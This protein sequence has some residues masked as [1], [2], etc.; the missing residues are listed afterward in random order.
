M[1]TLQITVD[2]DTQKLR[3]KSFSRTKDI[4][5]HVFSTM[6]NPNYSST[7]F[8][9]AVIVFVTIMFS[10]FTSVFKS[11]EEYHDY[12]IWETAEA[13]FTMIF[14]MELLLRVWS[15]PNREAL[16]WDP[17]TFIDVAATIPFYLHV[18]FNQSFS[19]MEVL[20][21]LRLWKLSRHYSGSLVLFHALRES[22]RALG[23]PAFFL[24][25]I[26]MFF[27]TLLYAIEPET[28]VSIPWAIYF[29]IVTMSTVGYGDVTASTTLGW[30]V[31]LILICFGVLFMAMPLG[32]M[33]S[34]VVAAW[35]DK[36]KIILVS[37]LQNHFSK[38]G[39]GPS[40]VKD[41]FKEIDTDG[42]GEIDFDE[43]WNFLMG[44]Q[45]GLSK[46][47][48]RTLFLAIDTS[49]QGNISPA[50]FKDLIFANVDKDD[51]MDEIEFSP[52]GTSR[53]PSTPLEQTRSKIS[54]GISGERAGSFFGNLTDSDN[55]SVANLQLQM[56]TRMDSMQ[57]Q[58]NE[59]HE[60]MSTIAA[61]L[62]A[63]NPD[64]S[65]KAT[66]KGNYK[67]KKK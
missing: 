47:E 59:M 44:L 4:R 66:Y 29:T 28:F 23:V 22:R 53:K 32:I 40:W 64:S 52:R 62:G 6:D 49:N 48:A 60:M 46:S 54:V 39:K 8:M 33:G 56:H 13:V 27:S 5:A 63:Q 61:Q 43:F 17:M 31:N 36:D 3:S 1:D 24:Y 67:G 25:L 65:A 26:M 2:S 21:V 14:T 38:N 42:S 57:N 16:F 55:K 35:K 50:E 30:V 45:M 19:W 11:I 18:L 51:N 10:T 7:A 34:F 58:M 9:V 12:E 41:A 20:R 15:C 37:K